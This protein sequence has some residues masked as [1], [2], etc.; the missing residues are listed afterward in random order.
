MSSKHPQ[1]RMLETTLATEDP[2]TFFEVSVPAM[3]RRGGHER[4]GGRY[5]CCVGTREW[6]VDLDHGRVTG[7]IHASAVSDDDGLD[8]VIVFGED[9]LGTGELS[10]HARSADAV[11]PFIQW[12]ASVPGS[13]SQ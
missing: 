3:L 1:L 8:A 2:V 6:V 10:I 4:F 7:D 11:T 13:P 12:L 9:F 5:G